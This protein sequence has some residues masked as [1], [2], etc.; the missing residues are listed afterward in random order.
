M[1]LFSLILACRDKSTDTA[2]VEDS[3]PPIDNIDTATT[4]EDSNTSEETDSNGGTGDTTDSGQENTGDG[5]NPILGTWTV[6]G[7]DF[8]T[9]TCGG[10]E[11]F[12]NERTMTLSNN[13]GVL[14]MTIEEPNERT[15]AFTC[16]L[17]ASEFAC[18]D[19]VIENT[20]PQLPCTLYYTHQLEGQFVDNHT[21]IG[22]Y[23]LRTTSSGGS[24]CSE[25][26][27]HF[28]TPCEQLGM[29]T[30]VFAQ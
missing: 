27:L 12:P 7:P 19:I 30:A 13:A 9:N 8:T 6:T 3:T 21:L 20:I 17:N 14:T 29:M 24:G 5:S 26:S 25:S 22:D 11:S 2:T 15:Y 23:A 10:G 1:F 16:T 18:D 4:E 28:P